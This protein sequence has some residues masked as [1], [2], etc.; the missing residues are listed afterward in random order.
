MESVEYLLEQGIETTYR[1]I[2]FKKMEVLC[3]VLHSTNVGSLPSA[4]VSGTR[5]MWRLCRVPL[6]LALGKLSVT[7]T[8]TVTSHFLYQ[9]Q[10]SH[11]VKPLPNARHK[12]LGK[13]AFVDDFFAEGPLPSASE[14]LPSACCT[15]QIRRFQ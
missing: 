7:V 15:R 11:S 14:R 6:Y 12:A 9:G 4:E 5:Q 3:R 13:V 8:P 1:T 2:F 10:E